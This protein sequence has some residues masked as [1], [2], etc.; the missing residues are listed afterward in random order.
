M[1][2]SFSWEQVYLTG[3]RRDQPGSDS[4]PPP[5]A[6]CGRVYIKGVNMFM[7]ITQVF[8]TAQSQINQ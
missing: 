7:M 5:F 8:V 6:E 4:D 2:K 3:T 1:M